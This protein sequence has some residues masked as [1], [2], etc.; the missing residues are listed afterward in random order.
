M[1]Q[2]AFS[3]PHHLLCFALQAASFSNH[4]PSTQRGRAVSLLHATQLLQLASSRHSR[5]EEA[6]H[7]QGALYVGLVAGVAADQAHLLG[8]PVQLQGQHLTQRQAC[9]WQPYSLHTRVRLFE[10]FTHRVR[11][12]SNRSWWALS[13]SRRRK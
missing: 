10:S 6:Q 1:E 13:Q 2:T 11:D 12:E 8:M 3:S 9:L 5:T 4:Y 7:L